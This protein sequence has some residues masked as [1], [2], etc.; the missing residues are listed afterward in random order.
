MPA[1]VDRCSLLALAVP[2]W[3]LVE[4]KNGD[5]YNGNLVSCDSWMNINLRE[6]IC[7]SKVRCS[8]LL[9]AKFLLWVH[10]LTSAAASVGSVRCMRAHGGPPALV[11]CIITDSIDCV[12]VRRLRF[13]AGCR[14]GVGSSCPYALLPPCLCTYRPLLD[15]RRN[16]RSLSR[17]PMS[18]FM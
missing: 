5:T 12:I 10:F 3:Q 17:I 4:L 14:A 7:T 18:L 1:L 6:V 2:S 16:P 11:S 9:R 8:S 15:V 13:R